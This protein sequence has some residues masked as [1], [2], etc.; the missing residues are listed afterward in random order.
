MICRLSQY[1]LIL[2]R[3]VQQNERQIFDFVVLY[4]VEER[5]VKDEEKFG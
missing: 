2:I 4:I 3:R 1:T 5:Y